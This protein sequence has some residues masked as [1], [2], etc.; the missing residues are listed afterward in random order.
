MQNRGQSELHADAE[1]PALLGVSWHV[2]R[3]PMVRLAILFLAITF[4]LTVVGFRV[5]SL[6]T[7]KA[8][9]YASEFLR[10][11]ERTESIPCL[12]GSILSSDGQILVQDV[13][14]ADVEV[15]YRWIEEPPHPQW[16]KSKVSARLNRSER[17][18]PDRVTEETEKFLEERTLLWKQLEKVTGVSA[19]ELL[20]RRYEVQS[21]LMRM[22]HR[23]EHQRELARHKAPLVLVAP[24]N[25]W[26]AAGRFLLQ[27]LATE[28]SPQSAEPIV[29]Q[30]E[31]A[32]YTLIEDVPARVRA[33]LQSHPERYPSLRV[34]DATRREYSDGAFAPHIV[35]YRKA[36]TQEE[37]EVRKKRFP[38][39][40]PLG[41]EP[42][43][44]IGQMGVERYHER[45]LRGV[46]GTRKLWLNSQGEIVKELV[47][48]EPRPGR[49]IELT[50]NSILQQQAEQILSAIIPTRVSRNPGSSLEG[51]L[52]DSLSTGAT[53]LP[54]ETHVP[55]SGCIVVMD[56]HSGELQA[57]V[58]WPSFNI[59]TYLHGTQDERAGLD[60][61]PRSPLFPRV[62]RMALPPGSVFKVVTAAA[63]LH[64]GIDAYEPFYCQGYLKTPTRHRCLPF[65]HKGV[66]HGEVDLASAMA[67][68]CNV[69]FFQGARRIGGPR[70]ID[71]SQRMGFG[72]VTGVDLP[73]EAM[74]TLPQAPCDHLGVAIGQA[75]LTVTP[76]QIARM[77]AAVAN[78]GELP[79]PKVARPSGSTLMKDSRESGDSSLNPSITSKI[80][81]GV[82]E[83][84][85]RQIGVGLERVVS[86]P[87]GT[88]YKTVR[89]Q[90]VQ[91]AG[92]T[93]T[94][95][96][97]GRVDHAWFAGYVPAKSPRYA[98][99]VVLEH[100]GSGGKS[101]GPVAK[102]LVQIMLSNGLL[103]Q[104]HVTQI[105]ASE[106]P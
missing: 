35:G 37:W 5:R 41:Y 59:N 91:I 83:S 88:G 74:G 25:I 48:R 69:Y 95:E 7:D 43:D 71:W 60:A 50:L 62:Y 9:G 1:S 46:R 82:S 24:R 32:Y 49:D 23:V 39:G 55:K 16:L 105:T 36:L 101:A 45:L 77:M 104:A 99:V 15:H 34:V 67:Q 6:Q 85:L 75:S 90:E 22:R 2:D 81:P 27:A 11:T 96:S 106:D 3:Y 76:M 87:Q 30:E 8:G 66:G 52:I 29:L 70:L 47:V 17:R 97:R 78:G 57:A 73:G 13:V 10:L 21:R 26:D 64:S 98:I 86:H 56:I 79:T 84:L 51:E 94:A 65:V 40:D 72:K 93:G 102:Q 103:G 63:M 53:R 38:D 31:L 58:S 61:D 42:G 14:T 20:A 12:D 80:I 68:S 92:K 28:S 4:P 54:G 33:E 44:R 18:R 19:K 89:M 100:G